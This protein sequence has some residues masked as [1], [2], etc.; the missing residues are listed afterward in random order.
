MEKKKK[1]TPSEVF[2]TCKTDDEGE[3][4]VHVFTTWEKAA[5][6]VED[7]IRDVFYE[8]GVLFDGCSDAQR[9]DIENVLEELKD[10]YC[11]ADFGDWDCPLGKIWIDKVEVDK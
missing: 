1:M 2:V 3:P 7:A 10:G 9:E 4:Y 8:D 11:N 5:K 6:Y